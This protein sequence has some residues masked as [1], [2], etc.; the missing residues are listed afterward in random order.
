MDGVPH[1]AERGDERQPVRRPAALAR[2]LG[3][4]RL[5]AT[6]GR[7]LALTTLGIP[8]ARRID[9]EGTA[10]STVRGRRPRRPRTIEHRLPE[11]APPP[12]PVVQR[13]AK[14]R[15]E[16]GAATRPRGRAA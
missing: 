6:G 3:G 7:A 13:V 10:G 9:Y 1:W 11:K 12:P 15:R 8:A 4:L 14:R 2:G 16:G 5:R